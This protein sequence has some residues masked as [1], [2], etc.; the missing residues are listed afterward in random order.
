MLSMGWF[1]EVCGSIRILHRQQ[2][3]W[4]EHSTVIR[5]YPA[6]LL[7]ISV[8]MILSDSIKQNPM[9]FG[10]SVFWPLQCI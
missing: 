7:L 4:K 9:V 2:S 8:L 5:K 1:W 6:M 10:K 3:D